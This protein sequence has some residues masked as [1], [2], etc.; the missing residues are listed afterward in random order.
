MEVVQ[1]WSMQMH[2]SQ[3]AAAKDATTIERLQK[4]LTNRNERYNE[5]YAN[6]S[7]IFSK[8]QLQKLQSGKR[9]VWQQRDLRDFCGLYVTSPSVYNML[10][11]RAYPLPSERKLQLGEA[12]KRC[13]EVDDDSESCSN[14]FQI[15]GE[16]DEAQQVTKQQQETVFTTSKSFNYLTPRLQN[17]YKLVSY[18]QVY[19]IN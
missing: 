3:L 19:I 13:Q 16:Q 4:Q 8:V 5:L 10:L 1:W 9:V 6:L 18:K 17:Q 2:I 14:R 15:E 7:R 12:T 11:K